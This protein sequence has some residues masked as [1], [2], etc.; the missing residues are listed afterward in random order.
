MGAAV[1]CSAGWAA[2]NS[3]PVLPVCPTHPGPGQ[4]SLVSC[5]EFVGSPTGL[6]GACG[7]LGIYGV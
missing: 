2:S 6:E 3:A 4:A 5:A 7:T 1:P